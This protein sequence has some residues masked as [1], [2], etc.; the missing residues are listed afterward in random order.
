M[1]K[2]IRMGFEHGLRVVELQIKGAKL[3]SLNLNFLIQLIVIMLLR[4]PIYDVFWHLGIEVE[5]INES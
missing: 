1:T 2:L 4:L 3:I 5:F